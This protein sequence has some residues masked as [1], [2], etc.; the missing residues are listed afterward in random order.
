MSDYPNT[1]TSK[2]LIVLEQAR[3]DEK[4]SKKPGGAAQEITN[5]YSLSKKKGAR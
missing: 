2:G 4:S 3:S 5:W 1:D